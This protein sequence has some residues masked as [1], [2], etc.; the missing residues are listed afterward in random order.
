[1]SAQPASPPTPA[2]AM[3]ASIVATILAGPGASSAPLNAYLE[4]YFSA[5][6]AESDTWSLLARYPDVL[7]RLDPAA[8][9]ADALRTGVSQN[10][11][12]EIT[13]LM[14]SHHDA[15]GA[16][17]GDRTGI[18][19]LAT[20]R[21][22]G[23]F[24]NEQPLNS[25]S[26]WALHWGS[27]PVAPWHLT[28]RGHA[29]FINAVCPINLNERHLIATAGDDGT[30]RL[31]NPETA[32]PV[33]IPLRGHDGAV[34]AMCIV[35][36]PR[37]GDLIATAGHDRT[38]RLWDPLRSAQIAEKVLGEAAV[39]AITPIVRE[40]G[41]TIIAA[42]DASGNIRLWRP[43]PD[44]AVIASAAAENG[45]VY[46]LCVTRRRDVP[47]LAVGNGG[48]IDCWDI[49]LSERV[50]P[51]LD[52]HKGEVYAIA[53]LRRPHT[54][55][56]ASAGSD[57]TVRIW[58]LESWTMLDPVLRGHHGAVY[59]LLPLPR[60]KSGADAELASGGSDGSIRFW[61]VGDAD[62]VNPPLV[63]HLSGIPGLA[64]TRRAD[65]DPLLSA[66]GGDGTVR[67]WP[68]RS[69]TAP[70][71][72]T[73]HALNPLG[74]TALARVAD[75]R[76]RLVVTGAVDG[77][78]R[79]L[80]PVVALPVLD[81]VQAHEDTIRAVC[82]LETPD[83]R[84]R[85]NCIATTS[86]DGGIR[87]WDVRTGTA[88]GAWE[89]DDQPNALA[90]L[91]A[92][93]HGP[94]L[95]VGSVHGGI[96]IRRL[97]DGARLG[98]SLRREQG[99]AVVALHAVLVEAD[100]EVLV[101]ASEDGAIEMWD[102]YA[103]DPSYFHLG[104]HDGTA[105]ALCSL[106]LDRHAVVASGGMDGIVRWW[107]LGRRELV[108][109]HSGHNGAVYALTAVRAGIVVSGGGDGTLRW[110]CADHDDAIRTVAAHLGPIEALTGFVDRPR[111]P[112]VISGGD[113]GTLMAWDAATGHSVGERLSTV[114]SGVNVVAVSER[115]PGLPL[116]VAAAG[117]DGMISIWSPR[118]PEPAAVR[119]RKSRFAGRALCAISINGV[120]SL[121]TAGGAEDERS[122]SIALRDSQTGAVTSTIDV[123][124]G[125][126]I[127]A[128]ATVRRMRRG[129]ERPSRI[130]VG[131]GSGRITL[132]SSD[133]QRMD[134]QAWVAH[135]GPVRALRGLRR[136]RLLSGGQDGSLA[137]WSLPAAR[138]SPE[139]AARVLGA[140][141]GRI[142]T[143]C[144]IPGHDA[145]DELVASAGEDADIRL[146]PVGH[147]LPESIAVL[148]G[149]QDQIR[150][151]AAIRLP[152]EST[153][154][155]SAG[156]D[157]TIRIWDMRR[158]EAVYCIPLHRRVL[159]LSWSSPAQGRLADS[160]L[161]VG[162]DGGILA[163]SMSDRMLGH[164]N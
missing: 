74:V 24:W 149:H 18:R 13:G 96:E 19:Q 31:W 132:L 48:V 43:S 139:E 2:A 150:A 34:E 72:S 117:D 51:P 133:L 89:S 25:T 20:A 42:G 111:R 3:H 161:I 33:G 164:R 162:V 29:G 26:A 59:S 136:G 155:A 157:E 144:A 90:L 38:V 47:L 81:S 135:D 153:L 4:R 5:H 55:L 145:A 78:L 70:E 143:L 67:V 151:M 113:D 112:L 21:H 69:S 127:L 17:P 134:H 60:R 57:A 159:G 104:S 9:T 84:G 124:P 147:G 93:P 22:R 101:S 64:A 140:H 56:I 1:M 99:N 32:S 94:V 71:G 103:D 85:R 109:E 80:D 156:D 41:P 148:S 128:L 129:A 12:D 98:R 95:A 142:W 146:W 138:E 86:R 15:L 66:A 76:G 37:L 141:S 8:V 154:L 11:P 35:P 14:S 73:S 40:T 160:E 92:G 44:N 52:R 82:S 23:R 10:L 137:L 119:S 107:D 120:E 46:A 83:G 68:L 62:S 122:G 106:D 58:D 125:V 79:F 36:D 158:R 75:R 45:A 65:G 121:V 108:R 126:P 87:L 30:V 118:A 28:L 91:T 53:V 61:R 163:L 39:C 114:P 88:V 97:R 49:D 50:G 123:N 131:D 54:D 63:G 7:D 77:K 16:A 115:E 102:I 100:R 110:W 130:A 105:I 27:I 116:R 6:V 152:D